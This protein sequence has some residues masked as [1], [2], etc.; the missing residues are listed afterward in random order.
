MPRIRFCH[1]CGGVPTVPTGK[2]TPTEMKQMAAERFE[3]RIIQAA[4]RLPPMSP[5]ETRHAIE[6]A[7]GPIPDEQWKDIAWRVLGMPDA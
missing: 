2:F 4:R 5:K 6:N 7:I 1:D 3:D